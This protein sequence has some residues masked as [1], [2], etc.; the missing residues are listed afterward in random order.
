MSVDTSSGRGVTRRGF[1]TVAVS[2]IVAGVVAGVGAYYAGTLSAPVKEV[3]KEVTKTVTSTTTLAPGAPATTTITLTPTT[4][5]TKTVTT[6]VTATATTP[7]RKE[8][9][10]GIGTTGSMA[11]VVGS[12]L[13]DTIRDV[14]PTFG[15]SSYPIGGTSANTKEFIKGNLEVT[16]SSA[17]DLKLL[18][19]REEWYKDIPQN[20]LMPVHTLYILT[21][22]HIIVTTPEFKE[23]YRLNSWKDLDGKKVT[24]Y[25]VKYENYKWYEKALKMLG[26]NF[27]HVEM[28]LDMIPDALKKGDIVACVTPI[29]GGTPPPWVLSLFTKV[30]TVAI[31]PS[32]DEVKVLEKAGL[33]MSWFSTKKYVEYGVDTLGVEKAFGV[34]LVTGW[35]THPK[36]MSED[37]V[38]K[39]LK[40]MISKKDELAKMTTYFSEFAEDPI[41]VQV[42]AISTAPEI[43]VHPGLARLLKEYGVWRSEWKVAV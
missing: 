40:T 23:K 22:Q 9:R 25:S 21:N 8:L 32:E 19:A 29:T 10:I 20:V 42:T 3:V 2:A 26:V 13:A 7:T 41:G 16:Y 36:F 33:A 43:P 1:L 39:L 28:D 35:N 18:Y 15:V 27:T 14:F 37:E 17:S 31:Y 6:T 30:K 38:Y 12:L 5:V 24:L 4:T 34:V 11:Y